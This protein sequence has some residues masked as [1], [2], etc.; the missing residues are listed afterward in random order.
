M[1]NNYELTEEDLKNSMSSLDLHL[2]QDTDR[3]SKDCLD[4]IEM[5]LRDKTKQCLVKNRN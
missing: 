1:I 3:G 4:P 2:L 5:L